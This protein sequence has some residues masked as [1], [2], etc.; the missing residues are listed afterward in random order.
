MLPEVVTDNNKLAKNP[1]SPSYIPSGGDDD[2]HDSVLDDSD[3]DSDSDSDKLVFSSLSSS[4]EQAVADFWSDFEGKPRKREVS[5]SGDAKA[6]EERNQLSG[7]GGAR[8]KKRQL[9]EMF[10]FHYDY[11]EAILG[12]CF[13]LPAPP[14]QKNPRSFS[15][16]TLLTISADANPCRSPSLASVCDIH[17]PVLVVLRQRLPPLNILR[18]SYCCDCFFRPYANCAWDVLVGD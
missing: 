14:P 7:E 4:Q 8:E 16:F 15:L 18:L 2:K 6:K 9:E 3:L 5:S 11:V 1:P 12:K 17:L 13:S 10:G